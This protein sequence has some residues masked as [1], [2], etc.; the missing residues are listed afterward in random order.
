MQFDF[1]SL[2]NVIAATSLPIFAAFDAFWV[3][4]AI[5][6]ASA[7]F[8]WLKKK[9]KTGET[10]S[11]SEDEI[12]PS[13]PDRSTKQA[14]RAPKVS[15]WEAELRRLLGEAPPSAPPPPVTP[16]PRPVSTPRAVQLSPPPP[17]VQRPVPAAQIPVV[18]SGLDREEEVQMRLRT[19]EKSK[20]AY[21]KASQLHGSVS[22]DL[23]KIDEQTERHVIRVTPVRRRGAVP[24]AALAVRLIRDPRTVRQ[25]IVASMVLGPPKA[26]ESE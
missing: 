4:V 20:V 10:D 22:E 21:Q 24:E 3:F 23:R 15:D 25:A 19:F 26:L 6:I 13:P 17:L 8:E 12:G 9:G 2:G 1:A 7:I 5:A 16:P 14:P 18:R 11:W